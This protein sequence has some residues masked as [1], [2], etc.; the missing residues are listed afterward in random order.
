MYIIPKNMS[1]IWQFA[2]FVLLYLFKRGDI[3][4]PQNRLFLI[5]LIWTKKKTMHQLI[6]RT[7]GPG[8]S[9]VGS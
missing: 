4:L 8:T 2:L 1:E 6:S 3:C 9:E 7:V 5:F